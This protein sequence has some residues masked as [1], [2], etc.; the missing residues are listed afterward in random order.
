MKTPFLGASYMARSPNAAADVC[1][2]L[3]PEA[4]PHGGKETGA[5]Y[6][7]PGTATL[8]TLGS[9]PIR[10][11]WQFGDYAYVVSGST[12][13]RVKADWGTRVLGTVTGSGP[14]S[15]A[16]NGTQLF[17]ACG[18]NAFI[19]NASTEVFAQITDPDFPG[20]SVVGYID[21]F[22]VFIQPDSQRLWQ[23]ALLDGT[24]IDPT[25][26]ASAEGSPDGLVS[27][28]VD[29]REIWL[30]GTR[31]VEVWYDVGGADFSFAPIQGAFIETGCA[32]AFSVSKMDN[33]VYWLGQ[34]QRGSG[35][36]Y[37]ANG[38]T[39][40][41]IST[42]AVEY[43]IAQ[44]SATYGIS[45]AI[46]YTSQEEGHSF[47]VLT[48]PAGNR[49]WGY[50]AATGLWHQRSYRVNA[51]NTLIRHRSNCY[52]FYQGKHVVGD[53][54]NGNLYEM[55]MGI[56]ADAGQLQKWT[57]AW[58]ALPTGGNNLNRTFQHS[59]QIDCETG[60]GLDGDQQGDNPQ[61]F[62]EWSDDGGHTWSNEHWRSMG[63]I[64]EYGLRVIYRRL[65]STEKLRDRVYRLS[66]TD[67]VPITLLGAELHM[68]PG[69]N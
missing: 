38:Y 67:P 6:R 12:L 10:G 43:D 21:G 4:I 64:G 14:V 69:A 65:G 54:E 60:V 52:T 49:T 8:V 63:R 9:G 19:Y 1:M 22:F 51:T 40:Q 26:F 5:L 28:I 58:R 36:V 46:S 23:T 24:S 34:D 31:S 62:L 53:F 7:A 15:M 25:E 17:V 27:L 45:D 29:H 2:N 33:S 3:F 42:H 61:V 11:A 59:L 68:S 47:Y 56:Y 57:R 39:P 66:G 55:S 44:I 50:D 41:R 30:F 35:I 20:A 16:D 32:A 48:F 13:Y 18:T 37:R